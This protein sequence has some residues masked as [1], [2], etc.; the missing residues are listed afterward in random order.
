MS[1]DSLW[2]DRGSIFRPSYSATWL[3]CAGS[4]RAGMYANDTAG[5]D[6]AIGTVFHLVMAEWLQH[7]RPDHWLGRVVTIEKDDGSANWDIVI[8]EEMF[9]YGEDCLASVSGI[10]GRRYIETTVDISDITPIP[11]QKG[12]CDLA[13]CE[14]QVLDITD[15]KYGRGVQ[16]FARDNTQLLLYAYG[17]FSEYDFIYDFQTIRMRIAQPRLNHFEVWEIT[18]EELIAFADWAR[19]RAAEAWTLNAP[20]SPSPKACQWCKR[21]VDCPALEALREDLA[22]M[23]FDDAE[24]IVSDDTMRGI[25]DAPAVP[26]P[27][28]P[29]PVTLPTAQLARILVYRKLMEGW[30]SDIADELVSRAQ[31]GEDVG[32]NWKLVEGRSRRRCEDEQKAAVEFEP[33]LGD[34]VWKTELQS[35]NQV[36]KLLKANGVPLKTAKELVRKF[37]IK[38]PGKPTLAPAGDNRLSLPNIVDDSFDAEDDAL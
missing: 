9:A 25:A 14:P 37:A 33:I 15:W 7:G 18:R 38:P 29:Q 34:A 26:A 35:P 19:E 27:A 28:L 8:D 36:E 16:V 4:L 12:T 32:P 24:L 5:E 22:D 23:S 6:A 10:R 30:F 21:R 17:F 11:N 13:I 31:N 20:R 1:D 3:N 2:E